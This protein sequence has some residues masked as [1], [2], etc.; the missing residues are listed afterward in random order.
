MS[1]EGWLAISGIYVRRIFLDSKVLLAGEK[2]KS[3]V[4]SIFSNFLAFL[5]SC[6]PLLNF[7]SLDSDMCFFSYPN[8][9]LLKYLQVI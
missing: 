4:H 9:I 2:G 7:L 6:F 5:E 3:W 8:L 1:G